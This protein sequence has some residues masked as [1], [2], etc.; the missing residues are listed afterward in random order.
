M[1]QPEPAASWDAARTLRMAAACGL[2]AYGAFEFSRS[3]KLYADGAIGFG[4]V[5]NLSYSNGKHGPRY[6]ADY[7]FEDSRHQ[8]YAGSGQ[9]S[10]GSYRALGVGSPISIRFVPSDPAISEPA[11]FAHTATTVAMDGV[12]IPV[13]FWLLYLALRRKSRARGPEAPPSSSNTPADPPPSNFPTIF[14]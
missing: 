13:S 2:L 12:C 4:T 6:R 9:I 14:R 7:R 3:S 5:T 1:N 10:R 11:E 8:I